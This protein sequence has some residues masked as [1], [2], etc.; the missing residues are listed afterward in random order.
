MPKLA[1]L[2]VCAA[3]AAAPAGTI[4]ETGFEQPTFVP[5]SIVGQDAWVTS[6]LIDA[7]ATVQSAVV[8]AGAQ[9]LELNALPLLASRW[10]WAAGQGFDPLAA[11]TPVVEVET[12]LLLSAALPAW[13]S[14]SWGLDVYDSNVD[15]VGLWFLDDEGSLIVW[16]GS[17]GVGLDTGVDVPRNEWHGFTTRLDYATATYTVLVDGVQA[18]GVFA[19][20]STLDFGDADLRVTAPAFDCAYV[21]DYAIHATPEPASLLLLCVAGLLLRRR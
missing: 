9:A 11:G 15:R 10:W 8:Y 13:R 1:I 7:G 4:Y 3:A 6:G 16:D 2:V 19:M 14:G 21:D 17:Q 18:G 12:H 20:G 5:G